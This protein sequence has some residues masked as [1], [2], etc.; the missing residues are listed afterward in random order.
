[1]GNKS[2]DVI[3]VGSG[4]GKTAIQRVLDEDPTKEVAV[5]EKDELGGICLNRGCRPSK[6]LLYPADLVRTINEAHQ[7]GIDG[8][9]REKDFRTVM[10]R[11]RENQDQAREKMKE[12][13]FARENVDYYQG[14]GKFRDPHTLEVNGETITGDTFFLC[15]GSKPLIPP[16]DG[17]ESVSYLTSKDVF[18]LEKLPLSIVIVGGGYIGAELGHFLSAMGSKVTIIGRNNQFIPDEDPEISA[19]VRREMADQLDLELGLEVTEV[20]Q[21]SEG[22]VTLTAEE[23]SGEARNYRASEVLIA[24]GRAPNNELLNP[25]NAEIELNERG[26]IKVDDELR[27]AQDHIW[28]MGDCIGRYLFK[29]VGEYEAEIVGENATD[30]P[31]KTVDYSSVPHAL[32][33][34]PEV[35]AA[36]M[37]LEEASEEYGEDELSIGFTNFTDTVKGQAIEAN[38]GM[39]KIILTDDGEILGASIVGPEASIL[40][41]GIVIAMENELGIEALASSIYVHPALSKVVKK[42]SENRVPLG[43]YRGG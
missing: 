24:T 28:A 33:T 35:A 8:A 4:S 9:I 37:S 40:I 12:T 36:G 14:T 21:L 43:E 2:Y 3:L 20:E 16:I 1:L 7:V 26:W 31:N 41:Q 5:V 38:K 42:A 6:H 23:D 18:D 11:T 13:F 19:V 39:V 25:E 27:T 22:E 15:T 30:G 34:R 32:F 17:I 10:E 29:H